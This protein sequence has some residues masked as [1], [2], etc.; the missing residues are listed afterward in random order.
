MTDNERN[1]RKIL[2]I[3]IH[4][5][6]QL[7]ISSM[8]DVARTKRCGLLSR[9]PSAIAYTTSPLSERSILGYVIRMYNLNG[10]ENLMWDYL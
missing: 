8:W 2:F 6:G 9:H 5:A 1:T 10:Y 4:A 7:I 3:E